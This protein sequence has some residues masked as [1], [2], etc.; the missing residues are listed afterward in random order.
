MIAGQGAAPVPQGWHRPVRPWTLVWVSL[1]TLALWALA[2]VWLVWTLRAQWEARVVLHDQAIGLSL[3]QGLQAHADV[4]TR[5]ATQ[6]NEVQTVQVPLKQTLQVR[7]PD[8][9]RSQARVHTTVPVDTAFHYE[10]LVPVET[11]LVAEVPVVGWL[12]PFKVRLPLRTEVPV[13][14]SVPIRADVPL[15]LD[16]TG[17]GRIAGP[18]SVPLDTVLRLRVPVRASLEAEVVNR[19]AFTLLEASP[20][21]PLRLDGSI[22]RLPLRDVSW[23]VLP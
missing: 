9:L 20:V 5:V 11:E 18:L 1:A 2:M 14:L 22:V 8:V 12:P 4:L 21:I 10:A 15:V 3:P 23:V 19:M 7:L 17:E 6:V 13:K 16:V